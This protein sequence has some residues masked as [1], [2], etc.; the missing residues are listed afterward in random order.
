MGY[1]G[2]GMSEFAPSGVLRLPK[3][4]ADVEPVETRA[5]LI[6]FAYFFFRMASY[7]ILRDVS[8]EN[9]H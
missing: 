6:S 1:R 8:F 9:M 5:V 3:H 7:F 4:I 2:Y